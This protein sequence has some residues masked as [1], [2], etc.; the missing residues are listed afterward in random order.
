MQVTR[1]SI[2]TG[3]FHCMELDIT[4]EQLNEINSPKTKRRL[5]QEIVPN[6]TAEER[7]F[8]ITGMNPREQ[9][10]LYSSLDS[11]EE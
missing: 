1:M 2:I 6:L 10:E 5:M 8:L 4:E 7:E 9:K 11:E 3:I